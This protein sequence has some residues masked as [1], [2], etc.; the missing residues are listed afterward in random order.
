M[1]GP[2]RPLPAERAFVVQLHVEAD[3]ARGRVVG[4]IV[5]VVSGQT[6]H[7]DTLEDLL[8]FID[9]VLRSRGCKSGLFGKWHLTEVPGND[10]TG[11][12][13]PGNPS[14]NAAPHDLGWDFYLGDLE[15][16]PR[17]VDT[18]AGGVAGIDPATNLGH[19]PVGSSMTGRLASAISVMGPVVQSVNPMIPR[20]PSPVG[21]AWSVAAS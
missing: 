6:V 5:H 4:R 16:A 19:T 1:S 11:D 13:N 20:A 7:F 10:P 9:R 18:T 21:P 15:G 8:T 17:A 2:D 3:V 14:G 12:L